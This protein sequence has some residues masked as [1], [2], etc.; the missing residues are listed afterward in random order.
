M[1]KKVLFGFIAGM[2]LFVGVGFAAGNYYAEMV[3]NQKEQIEDELQG[4]FMEQNAARGQQHHHDMTTYVYTQVEK[5]KERMY[6]YINTKVAA[7]GNK[8]LNEHA[9]AVD[10]A[11]EQLEKELKQK[12][13]TWS[14]E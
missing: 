12:I 3:M 7:D 14:D 2:F 6:E 9:E 13:D 11:I 8:R 5:L 4:Y 1:S 10:K